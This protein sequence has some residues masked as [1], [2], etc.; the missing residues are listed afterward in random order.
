MVK[1]VL[2]VELVRSPTE[3]VMFTVELIAGNSSR[4][5]DGRTGRQ[6]LPELLS[7][8]GI[9]DDEGVEV[10]GA[11]DLKLGRRDDSLSVLLD[12]GGCAKST[13]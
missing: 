1:S 5:R 13:L 12:P 10:S 2:S 9:L 4:K 11:A 6:A 3:K 8:V 7:L